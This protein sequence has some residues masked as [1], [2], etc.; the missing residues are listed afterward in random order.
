MASLFLFV[1][2]VEDATLL[3]KV[4][5]SIERNKSLQM[6]DIGHNGSV[7]NA[8]LMGA[9]ENTSLKKLSIRPSSH[10]WHH[11]KAAAA[12]LQQVRPQLKL[13]ID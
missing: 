13:H 2:G 8:V 3:K 4:I 1:Q 5:T 9:R 10:Q 7:L 6:L 12:Q 11:L